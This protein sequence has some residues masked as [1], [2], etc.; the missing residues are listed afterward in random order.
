M[1]KKPVGLLDSEWYQETPADQARRKTIGE[2][3]DRIESANLDWVRALKRESKQ[4]L[5]RQ[6]IRDSAEA[7]YEEVIAERDSAGVPLDKEAIKVL[8]RKLV[9]GTSKEQHSAAE[10]LESLLI[11]SAGGNAERREL[12][13]YLAGGIHVML[14]L[15]H[16]VKTRRKQVIAGNNR[17]E[18]QTAE[19]QA[20]HDLIA[21]KAVELAATEKHRLI[22][23]TVAWAVDLKTEYVRKA[24]KKIKS[25]SG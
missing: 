23:K 3:A 16:Q 18:Q 15:D 14:K 19:M 11:A 9:E 6:L 7:A 22:N 25:E 2:I 10:N 13:S 21:K 12:A 1:T 4:Q 20:R 5:I 24:R 17:G 8:H